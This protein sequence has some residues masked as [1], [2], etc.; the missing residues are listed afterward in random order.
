MMGLFN[1]DNDTD[2]AIHD[3]AGDS[4]STAS[5]NY[6]Q[7]E[8]MEA[9]A[10][11]EAYTREQVRNFELEDVVSIENN[12]EL[13]PK[14]KQQIYAQILNRG[15]DEE[16]TL[17]EL[18]AYNLCNY[19]VNGNLQ[20]LLEANSLNNKLSVIKEQIHGPQQEVP[21]PTSKL[22]KSEML[23]VTQQIFQDQNADPKQKQQMMILLSDHSV[24]QAQ[25]PVNKMFMLIVQDMAGETNIE[26][27]KE[28][29]KIIKA[30]PEL[31][32]EMEVFRSYVTQKKSNIVQ[33]QQKRALNK[34]R[35]QAWAPTMSMN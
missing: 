24:E 6:S 25:T 13:D 10:P 8:E 4:T 19:F 7:Y 34:N 15:V 21:S 17:Q 1:N 2:N 27:D 16:S 35:G 3:I 26:L 23:N 20:S 31:A 29:N 12:P 5:Q 32:P 9:S 22:I 18:I 11:T 33:Q 28:Y 14:Q 30:T